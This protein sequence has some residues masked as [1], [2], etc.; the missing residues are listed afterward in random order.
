MKRCIADAQSNTARLLRDRQDVL[1]LKFERGG[2]DHQWVVWDQSTNRYVP[3]GEDPDQ[4]GLPAWVPRPVTNVYGAVIRGLVAILDQSEPAQVFG[5]KRDSDEDRATA[6]VVED[7]APVLREECGYDSEGHRAQ[8]NRAATLTDKAAYILYYD[9]DEKWGTE[10]VPL[11]TCKAEGCPGNGEPFLPSDVFPEDPVEG[12]VPTG[13]C[14]HCG[15][16]DTEEAM[17]M[18]T[19]NGLPLTVALPV[20]RIRGE[21]I[22]S[23]EFSVPSSA[24]STNPKSYPWILLH[25]RVAPEDVARMWGE[26]A[27]A[28]ARDRRNHADGALTRAYA[29]QVRGLASPSTSGAQGAGSTTKDA[30]GPVVYRLLHDPIEDREYYFPQGLYLVMVADHILDAGP[31]PFKDDKGNHFKNVLVRTWADSSG[32]AFGHPPADDLVPIQQSRNLYEALDQLI[33][34]HEAAPTRYIPESVTLIDEPTG[35][36]GDTVRYRSIDGQKPFETRGGAI[37]DAMPKRIESCD[38]KMQEVS[39]LNSVLSGQRP[40]GDPTL[41]EV[42]IL[43][44]RGMAA[45]RAPL[46]S[47]IQFEIDLTF[48]L[49]HVARQCAWSPRFRRIRGENGQWELTQFA[50]ADLTGQVDITVARASA[51]P[52]S[53]LM[54]QLRTKD[55]LELGVL[56]PPMQDPELQT[57]LL[58]DMDLAHL[59]KSLDEDRRQV[60]REI[61]R[62]KA[63][64]TPQEILSRPPDPNIHNLP[65]HIYLKSQF[66]KTEEAEDLQTASP[67]LFGAMVQWIAQA[68]QVL[69]MEQQQ[70]AAAQQPPAPP[71]AG[72]G[73]GGATLQQAIDS[74][75]L[76]PGGPAA[77]PDPLEAAIQ[78]GALVPQGAVP[79]PPQGPS[80]D[81][82]IAQKLITPLPPPPAMGGSV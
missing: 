72:Q 18:A 42:Q 31:L 80:V 43:Q 78:A 36:P 7:A 58:V 54:Q 81:D 52:K 65:L 12:E 41:G 10:D 79:P 24:R 46:D 71:A 19:L 66:L 25:S 38:Q 67:P 29:D 82:L 16:T 33:V 51:W 28:I 26:Q 59:K 45:F 15:N 48:M 37:N 5:P 53:P 50:A 56:P 30:Q 23:M 75:A 9:H 22:P 49:L 20:G 2:K 60:A 77:P 68:K 64:T 8:L 17:E 74:G 40:S 27:G 44:E 73:D 21:V 14:P 4:G 55:A 1:N 61:D 13:A 76:V 70:A 34:M 62:W 35:V 57:A 39:G 3:R 63:A 32:T 69:L 47:L 11:V 6:D